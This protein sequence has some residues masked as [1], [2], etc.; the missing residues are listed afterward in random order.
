MDDNYGTIKKIHCLEI[1]NK[2]DKIVDSN[3]ACI[4][5]SKVLMQDAE[6]LKACDNFV[7]YNDNQA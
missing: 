4:K 6:T 1:D 3:R 5:I 2:I 7:A